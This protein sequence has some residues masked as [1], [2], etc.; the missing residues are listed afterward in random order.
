MTKGKC[1]KKRRAAVLLLKGLLRMPVPEALDYLD[2]DDTQL[3]VKELIEDDLP[4][5]EKDYLP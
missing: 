3:Y 1:R 4:K 5:K 2:D